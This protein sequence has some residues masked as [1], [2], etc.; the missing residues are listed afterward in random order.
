MAKVTRCDVCKQEIE[1]VVVKI[2]YSPVLDKETRPYNAVHSSY[3]HHADVCGT[4]AVKVMRAFSWRKRKY[5][6]RVK[7]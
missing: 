4:C 6:V 7:T 1:E 2:F 3:T 5:R